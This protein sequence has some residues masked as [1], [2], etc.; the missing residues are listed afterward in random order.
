MYTQY[1]LFDTAGFAV[2]FFCNF[3]RLWFFVIGF[4]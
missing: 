3:E 1:D 2:V 4:G